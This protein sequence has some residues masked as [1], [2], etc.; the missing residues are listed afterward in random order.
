[1]GRRD[2]EYFRRT[3]VTRDLELNSL[4]TWGLEE[5]DSNGN[6]EKRYT[7]HVFFTGPG[8]EEIYAKV[9]YDYS[10]SWLPI[11]ACCNQLVIDI[12]YNAQLDL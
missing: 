2:C 5:I 4:Q 7:R 12:G 8:G 6:K 3:P 1:M 9:V 10:E 11:H